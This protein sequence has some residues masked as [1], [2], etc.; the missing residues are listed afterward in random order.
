MKPI[1]VLSFGSSERFASALS[2]CVPSQDDVVVRDTYELP[3]IAL[4]RFGALLI[5]M[6]CDQR[7]LAEQAGQ[8]AAFIDRGGTVVA[9]GHYA[10]PFLPGMTGFHMIP[11]CHLADLAIVRIADHPIWDGVS[12]HDLTFRRGVAGFYARVWHEAPDG[13]QIINGLGRDDRPVD[14]VYR[15]GRGRILFHGGNDLWQFRGDDTT[16]SIVPQLVRW[17]DRP[18]TAQ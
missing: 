5:S 6:H 3:E 17:L 8:I 13:A 12:A 11:D 15:V 14:L 9:N 7:F 18:E 16:A 2:E 10:Y 4:D 1:L